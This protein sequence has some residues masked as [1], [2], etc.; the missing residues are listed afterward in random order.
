MGEADALVNEVMAA[1]GYPLGDFDQRA[2]D[3]SVD[4]PHVV[5]HYRAARDLA[6]MQAAGKSTTEDLRQALVH[7]RAL[8]D[9]LLEWKNPEGPV[10]AA[11]GRELARGHR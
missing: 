10:M 4:H 2:D 8:F 11:R 7:Y 5:S 3:I 1:R 9:D 6:A